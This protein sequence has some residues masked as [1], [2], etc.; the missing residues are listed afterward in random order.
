MQISQFLLGTF[1]PPLPLEFS[2]F[3]KNA[4]SP[5]FRS[6]RRNCRNRSFCWS[7]LLA[8]FPLEFSNFSK[9]YD[10]SNF[11]HF[12]LPLANLD[13]HT[14]LC[15]SYPKYDSQCFESALSLNSVDLIQIGISLALCISVSLGSYL[16]REI[17]A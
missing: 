11:S 13:I 15:V 16:K 12:L 1:L 17:L 6:F 4:I 5:I 3:T 9:N 10:R 14:R 7:G 8:P 2:N